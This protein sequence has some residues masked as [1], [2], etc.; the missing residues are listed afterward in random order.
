LLFYRKPRLVRVAT[1]YGMRE[2]LEY[3]AVNSLTKKWERETTWGGKLTENVVQAV[4]RDLIAEAM[5]RF[6]D[7]GYSVVGTVHDEVILEVDAPAADKKDEVLKIM[8]EVP[9][10]A[11]G[12]PLA[13]DV[14]FG[15][16]YGK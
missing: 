3:S 14:G 10:W 15:K 4:C 8:C 5:L 16:R 13:A 2:V 12:F 7:R 1:E 11:K 6:R 9:D